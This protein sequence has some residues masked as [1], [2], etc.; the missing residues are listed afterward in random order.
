M[1]YGFVLKN[2]NETIV[3]GSGNS[4][5]DELNSLIDKKIVS[6]AKK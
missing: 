3:E 4:S 5:L 2:G 1:K 6:V